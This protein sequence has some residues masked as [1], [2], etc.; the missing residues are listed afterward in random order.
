M[1]QLNHCSVVESR[2]L[3]TLRAETLLLG[4][5]DYFIVRCFVEHLS[6]NALLALLS[7]LT[8]F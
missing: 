3:S 4:V 2:N 1:H 8:F 6:Q 7:S 5:A